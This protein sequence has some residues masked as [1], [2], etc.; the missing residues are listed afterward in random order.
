VPRFQEPVN[1]NV[2]PLQLVQSHLIPILGALLLLL[3]VAGVAR[4]LCASGWLRNALSVVL[5]LLGLVSA[6]FFF[7]GAGSWLRS[8]RAQPRPHASTAFGGFA[9]PADSN[10]RPQ[11]HYD[12]QERNGSSN[13]LHAKGS[14]ATADV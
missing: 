13:H 8:H 10:V 4:H 9:R 2:R 3:A 5:V 11:F 1:R 6:F 14:Q 12:S 7:Y